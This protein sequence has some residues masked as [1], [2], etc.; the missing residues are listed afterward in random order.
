M[1]AND[2]LDPY[3]SDDEIVDDVTRLRMELGMVCR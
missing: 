1:S 2:E 3:H